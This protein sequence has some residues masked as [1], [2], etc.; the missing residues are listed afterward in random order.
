VRDSTYEDIVHGINL[1]DS[2]GRIV[3]SGNEITTHESEWGGDAY[4]I[5]ID[6][7]IWTFFDGL[8]PAPPVNLTLRDNVI[9]VEDGIAAISLTDWQHAYLEMEPSLFVD[10]RQNEIT[11]DSTVWGLYGFGLEDVRLT[12]NDFFGSVFESGIWLEMT[13]YGKCIQNGMQGM[14]AGNSRC[15]LWDDTYG[16]LFVGA[17]AFADVLDMTDDPGTPEY[18]GL[19]RIVDTGPSLGN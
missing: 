4:G 17:G 1:Q 9:T 18:D 10:A 2:G 11:A 12:R 6:Q 15:L 19:N 3:F 16:N 14:T 7:G 13:A 5:L 8:A